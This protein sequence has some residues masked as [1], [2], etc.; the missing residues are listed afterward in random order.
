MHQWLAWDFFNT[1]TC[2]NQS[3]NSYTFIHGAMRFH[4]AEPIIVKDSL[5]HAQYEGRWVA[6]VRH[7]VAQ[8]GTAWQKWIVGS[9]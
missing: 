5:L 9:P 7:S 3:C 1:Y 8:R 6:Q 4:C 2:W